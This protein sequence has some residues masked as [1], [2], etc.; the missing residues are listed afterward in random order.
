MFF[1]TEN[2]TTKVNEFLEEG[3]LILRFLSTFDIEK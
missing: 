3:F 1:L 2:K